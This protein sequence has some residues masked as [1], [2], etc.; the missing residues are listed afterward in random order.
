MQ[1]T[2]DFH[3][4]VADACLPEAAGVVDDAT[5]LDAAVDVLDAHTS[6]GDATI[7]GFLR[8]CKGSAPGLPRRHD[9]LDVVQCERQEAEILEQPAPCGQ[10]VRGHIGNPLIVGAAGRGLTQKENR[11]GR[12]DQPHV[13]HRMVC[14]LTAITARL[15]SRILGALDAPFGAIV[16]KRGEAVAD[17]GAAASG[18]DVP[19]SSSVGLT[20]AAASAS[21][22][23]R[24]FA[25]AARDR[26]G[27]SP[28]A[29]SATRSTTKRT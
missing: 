12:V 23:P 4:Q 29:R 15:L 7:R 2:A 28:S 21:V 9:D 5:A 18:S 14:F 3:D 27:A 8:P 24:R 26:V 16:A 17:A 6:A 22:I 20:R 1:R 10:R 11:E 25:K 19:G 13:F